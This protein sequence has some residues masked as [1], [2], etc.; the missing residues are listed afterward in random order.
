MLRKETHKDKLKIETFELILILNSSH[1]LRGQRG[2]RKHLSCMVIRK[3]KEK[4]KKYWVGLWAPV[5]RLRL[6]STVKRQCTVP[7]HTDAF[8]TFQ[9]YCRSITAML[10]ISLG[11]GMSGSLGT[12]KMKGRLHRQAVGCGAVQVTLLLASEK[13]QKYFRYWEKKNKNIYM[14][15]C[16]QVKIRVITFNELQIHLS[17]SFIHI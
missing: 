15:F 7:I 11:Y 2:E 13:L 3:K 6:C 5:S 16:H 17:V 4:K 9:H 1:P 10:V 12:W 8:W 14:T